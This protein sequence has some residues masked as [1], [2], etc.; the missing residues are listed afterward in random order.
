MLILRSIKSNLVTQGFG[1]DQTKASL[2]PMYHSLGLEAHNGVDFSAITGEEIRFNVDTRGTVMKLVDSPTQGIGVQ[3]ATEDTDGQVYMHIYWHLKGYVV[4][5]GDYLD[6]GDLIGYADN[7]GRSTGTH[8]HYGL[9]KTRK[10][11]NGYQIQNYLNGYGGA[12][13]P[14]PFFKN[15]YVLNYIINL[16][17][18]VGILQ[19]LVE[20]VRKLKDK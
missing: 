20:L 18:Q 3:V 16:Q 15:I 5:L 14:W 1:I 12:I 10:T 6:T 4:K 7:T 17:A 9:Y 2:L 19:K 8:L 11:V 13:N